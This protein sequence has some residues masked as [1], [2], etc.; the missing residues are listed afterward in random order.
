MNTRGLMELMLDI[1]LDIKV[2][3]PASM[4]MVMALV[5]PSAA[6]MVLSVPDFAG[7]ISQDPF[8]GASRADS[9]IAS[10]EQQDAAPWL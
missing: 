1:G 2:I 3:S 6:E 5:R 4:M 10:G 7:T 9:G 8:A